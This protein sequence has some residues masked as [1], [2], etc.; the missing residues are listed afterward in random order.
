MGFLKTNSIRIFF[1]IFAIG[2]GSQA[3]VPVNY[4]GDEISDACSTAAQVV[5]LSNGPDGFLAVKDS[6]NIKAKRI[7]KILNGQSLWICEDSADGLWF[8]IVYT[9]KENLDCA[10]SSSIKERKAYKGP[11]KSGWVSKKYV[12]VLAG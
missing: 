8:G 4:G 1:I 10:V 6:P 9:S 5:N 3:G 7:D 11:C 2:F 12:K